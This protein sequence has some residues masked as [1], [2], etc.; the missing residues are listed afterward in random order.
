MDHVEPHIYQ[1]DGCQHA[2]QAAGLQLGSEENSE[3][4]HLQ[5]VLQC[6]QHAEDTPQVPL[7]EQEGGQNPNPMGELAAA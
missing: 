2:L 3:P 6:C 1:D 7:P 5:Q 4:M